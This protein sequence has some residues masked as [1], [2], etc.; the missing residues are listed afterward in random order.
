MA[1]SGNHNSTFSFP[2]LLLRSILPKH[3]ENWNK[4]ITFTARSSIKAK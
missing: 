2:H 1:H 4:F 3:L